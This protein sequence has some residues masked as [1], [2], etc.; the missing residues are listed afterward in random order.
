M[1]VDY[2]VMDVLHFTET[3]SRHGHHMLRMVYVL[4]CKSAVLSA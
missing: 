4:M 1:G 3:L 2:A